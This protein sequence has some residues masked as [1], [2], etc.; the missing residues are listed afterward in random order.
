MFSTFLLQQIIGCEMYALAWIFSLDKM[1]KYQNVMMWLK[2]EKRI[3]GN[4]SQFPNLR[5][6]AS[7]KS[8]DRNIDTLNIDYCTRVYQGVPGVLKCTGVPG[9]SFSLE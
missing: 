1:P 4:R 3:F 9:V 8:V 5:W 6:P 2:K 7:L